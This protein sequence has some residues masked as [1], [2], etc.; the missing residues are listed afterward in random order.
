M[1]LVIPMD[2]IRIV[3]DHLHDDIQTL[4]ACSLVHSSW[5][6][7]ARR[8]LFHSLVIRIVRSL[9][10]PYNPRLDMSSFVER[11]IGIS[12]LPVREYTRKLK[13]WGHDETQSWGLHWTA[14]LTTL[15][16]LFAV[17]PNVS[18][19]DFHGLSLGP[20]TRPLLPYDEPDFDP[21]NSL[22]VPSQSALNY[23]SFSSLNLYNV[24]SL[25]VVFDILGL[26][27]SVDILRLSEGPIFM[28]EQ[29]VLLEAHPSSL[30]DVRCLQVDCL[31]PW[32]IKCLFHGNRVHALRSLKSIMFSGYFT[33]QVNP[34]SGINFL[35][36]ES[37]T[38][39]HSLELSVTEVVGMAMSSIVEIRRTV[40]SDFNI[41]WNTI[42]FSP[43]TS[44][45]RLV[46]RSDFNTRYPSPFRRE[47]VPSE[48]LP[49]H[50]IKSVLDV[51]AQFL[52]SAPGPLN[53]LELVIDLR[54]SDLSDTL[55]P[56]DLMLAHT[57]WDRLRQIL[58]DFSRRLR[59][60]RIRY[61]LSDENGR[62]TSVWKTNFDNLRARIRVEFMELEEEGILVNLE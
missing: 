37:G 55:Y 30:P 12:T 24:K 10:D 14:N 15:Q 41:Y 49:E 3:I 29:T 59:P 16:K 22:A 56:M 54:L 2:V 45:R 8:Y 23:V 50:L 44:L 38:S 58:R 42:D 13:I 47:L 6:T 46:I 35:L 5:T 61:L 9:R 7:A 1:L 28:R 31:D 26:F 52:A 39:L 43:C 34:T 21:W 17:F 20:M 11:L 32:F 33:D 36:R 25:S 18:E 60:S 4:L 27:S 51:L 62:D 48:N 40:E 57:S 53:S 19:L